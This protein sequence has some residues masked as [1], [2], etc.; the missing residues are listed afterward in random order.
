MGGKEM[1]TA[2]WFVERQARDGGFLM[3]VEG[4]EPRIAARNFA[5]LEKQCRPNNI[6]DE[7]FED[8]CRQLE[9]GDRA[10]INVPILG[11]FRQVG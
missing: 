7:L 5:E 2:R 9:N 6:V 8:V 1:K 10:T 3:W 11:K 4:T